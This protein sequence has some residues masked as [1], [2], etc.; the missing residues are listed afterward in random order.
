VRI[1]EFML[2][3]KVCSEAW[4]DGAGDAFRKRIVA[5]R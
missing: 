4:L 2:G 5:A 3:R 1:R